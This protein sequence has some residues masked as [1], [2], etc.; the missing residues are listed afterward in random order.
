[1]HYMYI[2]GGWTN[3]FPW[4]ISI[5]NYK[6]ILHTAHR[7][8]AGYDWCWWLLL[9]LCFSSPWLRCILVATILRIKRC[10]NFPSF[11]FTDFSPSRAY[12]LPTM[13]RMSCPLPGSAKGL[14]VVGGYLPTLTFP[15]AGE[16]GGGSGH[17]LVGLE[18][19]PVHMV[20]G[21]PIL[22]IFCYYISFS[23]C[24]HQTNK[25]EGDAQFLSVHIV[26]Y[27]ADR[28]YPVIDGHAYVAVVLNCSREKY[29]R[30][31]WLADYFLF[32][33]SK[34]WFIKMILRISLLN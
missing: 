32:R 7:K 3:N 18:A 28:E 31:F 30:H 11:L 24:W 27:T 22:D 9:F 1:M 13:S 12:L 20:G 8:I 16:G 23:T 15:P 34:T 14:H 10:R 26:K 6:N 25:I 21:F 5:W 17:Q 29:P 33:W 4:I 19:W 2:S